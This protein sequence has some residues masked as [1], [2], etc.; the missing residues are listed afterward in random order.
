MSLNTLAPNRHPRGRGCFTFSPWDP[1]NQMHSIISCPDQSL[2]SF[3][4]SIAAAILQGISATA[5]PCRRFRSKSNFPLIHCKDLLILELPTCSLFML[6]S[7]ENSNFWPRSCFRIEADNQYC[8]RRKVPIV[9]GTETTANHQNSDIS[10][11]RPPLSTR[12]SC[13][14]K[15]F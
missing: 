6:V 15:K 5:P 9:R 2:S 12:I 11:I 7:W 10:E 3:Y 4:K 14:E 1:S 13:V 8:Q